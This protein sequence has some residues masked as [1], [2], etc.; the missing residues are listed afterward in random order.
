MQGERVSPWRS[1]QSVVNT[2]REDL[3]D[4]FP[5]HLNCQQDEKGV[6]GTEHK[7]VPPGLRQE[8][9]AAQADGRRLPGD[10]DAAGHNQ[11]ASG[12]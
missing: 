12:L 5:W 11:E 8:P 2:R 1:V 6:E 7:S 4:T 10:T 3:W 9:G